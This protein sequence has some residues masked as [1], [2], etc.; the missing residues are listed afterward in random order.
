MKKEFN[1]V[2]ARLPMLDA[3]QKAKGA[4]LFTDDLILPGMLYGKILRSPLAHAKILNIDTTKAEKLAGVKG[5]VTGKDIPDRQYGIVPKARDEYALAKDKVRYI[6][7]DVAAVCA[8]DPEIAEEALDL[9]KVD[10]EEL[11]AVFDPLESKKEGAPII[12]DG[13]K[14]NTSFAM[15]KEFGDVE[16][17]FA[18]CDAI[19][20]DTFFSQAV[21]HAPLEPHAALAQFDPLNGELTIWSSTQIPFFFKAKSIEYP[22]DS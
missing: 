13:V 8:I 7:D 9:I 5:V 4:A 17:A 15:Y 2:G 19:Y 3:A 16:K 20:E 6:G 1:V 11:P 10:Y 12:H 22:T 14:N 18:E 21:N